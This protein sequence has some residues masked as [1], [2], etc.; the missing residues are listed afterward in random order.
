M[1]FI[2]GIE[3]LDK[4]FPY[5]V[6]AI[7]NFDGVHLGHQAIFRMLAER[8][9]K[10]N[11]TSVVLTFEPHPLRIIAPERAPR[12]LTLF[13]D[14]IKLIQSFGIDAVICINFTREFAHIKAE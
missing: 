12:L 6:L 5:P 4:K 14:K 10:K 3:N 1:K 8:A 11:G 7:G 13:K 2:D 9:K